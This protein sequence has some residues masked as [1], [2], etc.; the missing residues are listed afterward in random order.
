MQQ[1]A[2]AEDYKSAVTERD[3]LNMLK[4]QQRRVELELDKENRI[5]RYEIGAMHVQINCTMRWRLA[6]PCTDGFASVATMMRSKCG[7][8]AA[9]HTCHSARR[10]SPCALKPA[11]RFAGPDCPSIGKMMPHLRPKTHATA[12]MVI[13]HRRY[14]YRGVILG[15]DDHCT[16]PEAWIQ[17]GGS[18]LQ[19]QLLGLC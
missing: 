10:G 2:S 4:L 6:V 17:V 13:R 8:D 15:H 5:I 16:A 1:A 3:A 18:W 12:G 11:T 9:R 7:I 14:S 19:T